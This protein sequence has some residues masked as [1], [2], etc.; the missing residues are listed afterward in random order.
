MTYCTKE[1]ERVLCVPP[2]SLQLRKAR[3][4]QKLTQAELAKLVGVHQQTIHR[5]ELGKQKHAPVKSTRVRV[6]K[7]LRAHAE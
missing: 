5:I 2:Y 4:A 3:R 6:D 7:W 1:L